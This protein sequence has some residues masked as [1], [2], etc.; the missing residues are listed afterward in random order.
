MARNIGIAL[1]LL[2]LAVGSRI[3][4]PMESLA[5]EVRADDLIPNTIFTNSMLVSLLVNIALIVL[6]VVAA[7]NIK[8][9]PSGWQNFMEWVIESLYNLFKGIN[10]EYAQR[11]FPVI[12]TIFFLVILS[13]WFGLF[14]GVGSIGICHAAEHNETSMS[15]IRLAVSAP[16]DNILP[17]SPFAEG[18]KYLGCQAGEGIIPFFRAPSADLNFTLALAL[19]SV[20]YTLYLSISKLG[21]GYFGKFFN[22]N[23]VMSFVGI[24]EFISLLARIPAFTFRLFGNIFAGEVLLIVMIFLVP[25]VVP[26]PFYFFEVF[27]GF[28]QAFVFAVLTMA[29]I[30]IETQDHNEH[31]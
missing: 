11:A 27:V 29:F 4:Y 25:L 14:P 22:L 24:L 26:L 3:I 10:A 6:A 16:V 12:A 23:G 7:G 19:I 17:P 13:N 20:F 31:H 28:I 1:A 18:S 9:V 15:E 30:A 5:I 2:A 8:A 21:A